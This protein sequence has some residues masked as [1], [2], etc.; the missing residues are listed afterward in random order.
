[1]IAKIAAAMMITHFAQT[2]GHEE[3]ASTTTAAARINLQKQSFMIPPPLS[4]AMPLY[5]EIQT[6]GKY[7]FQFP[8]ASRMG[9]RSGDTISWTRGS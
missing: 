3:I 7:E 9:F 1:M 8:Q 5:Y 6:L 4:S 2:A